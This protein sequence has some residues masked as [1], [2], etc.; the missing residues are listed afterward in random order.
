MLGRRPGQ[1]S[2]IGHV[3]TTGVHDHGRRDLQ[4]PASHEVAQADPPAVRGMRG[5]QDL[6][7]VGDD[8]P[9]TGGLQR[10]LGYEPGVVVD[11]Q[12]VGVLDATAHHRGVHRRLEALDGD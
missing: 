9:V 5:G 1:P 7:P 4:V 8:R 6:D 12:V 11:Q 10:H 3:R 2:D